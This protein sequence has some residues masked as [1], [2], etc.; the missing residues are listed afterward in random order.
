MYATFRKL[1]STPVQVELYILFE[2]V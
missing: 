2:A 1:D